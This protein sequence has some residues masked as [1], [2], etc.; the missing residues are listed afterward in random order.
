MVSRRGSAFDPER[1]G[2]PDSHPHAIPAL[3][4]AAGPESSAYLVSHED[5][6]KFAKITKYATPMSDTVSFV[7]FVFF[8]VE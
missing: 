4:A 7:T 6:T 2:H 3:V 8:V 5:A 1:M